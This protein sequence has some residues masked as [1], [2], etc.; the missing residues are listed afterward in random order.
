[1]TTSTTLPLRPVEAWPAPGSLWIPF[2]AAIL[3]VSTLIHEQ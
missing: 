1:V 2:L 3:S